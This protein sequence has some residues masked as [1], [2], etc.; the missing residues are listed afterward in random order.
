MDLRIG[1]WFIK[2]VVKKRENSNF[3]LMTKKCVKR[4]S[5]QRRNVKLEK[6]SFIAAH[7]SLKRMFAKLDSINWNVTRVLRLD[8]KT[9][10]T[11]LRTFLE[12]SD[13]RGEFS[14]FLVP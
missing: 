7:Y 1:D 4:N 14:S 5:I 3:P 2:S 8:F 13:V 10:F 9:N 12:D 6:A 11:K